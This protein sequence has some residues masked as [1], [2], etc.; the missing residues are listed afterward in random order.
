MNMETRNLDIPVRKAL[1]AANADAEARLD[2]GVVYFKARIA[3]QEAAAM[4]DPRNRTPMGPNPEVI[5]LALMDL[6]AWA[7][8]PLTAPGV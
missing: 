6:A 4:A 5:R 3:A 7:L 8:D 2:A 1:V